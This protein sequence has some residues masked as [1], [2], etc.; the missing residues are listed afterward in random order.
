MK[1]IDFSNHQNRYVRIEDVTK[2]YIDYI[3]DTTSKDVYYPSYHI[4]PPHGLLNDPNGLC[5]IN[6]E[7]HIFYQWFPLGPV[8]GLKHWYHL[9]TTDFINYNDYGNAMKPEDEFDCRG[10]Y[11]GMTLPDENTTHIY[12]TGIR[13]ENNIPSVCYAELKENNIIKQG[14]ICDY[15]ERHTT[16]NFRD[17]YVFK[18]DNIYYMIVGGESLSNKGVLPI[19]SSND[20]INFQYKGELKLMDYPFGYMLECPNYFESDNKGVLFFSP[21]GIESPNKYDFRNVFSVV[22]AVGEELDTNELKFSHETFYEMDKGFDFYAPQSFLD[23]K[24]RR[25][26]YGWLGNSK[27]EY[28][29]DKNNWAH[30]LTIPREIFIE[31]DRLR[32]WPIKELNA[33]RKNMHTVHNNISI[34]ECSFEIIINAKENFSLKIKNENNEYISFSGGKKEYCLDRTHMTHLYNEKYGTERFAKR[35]IKEEHEIRIYV[36]HSSIEIFADNGFTIF[37]SRFYLDDVSEVQLEGT[38]G[39]FFTLNSI[40]KKQV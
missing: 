30:M 40:T 6:D 8:H 25:I 36:D 31:N 19:Y 5:Q 23:G 7:V 18:K 10:C 26:L 29:S 12:Y 22:Y 2:K 11:S 9:S 1:L 28:P 17:P 24:G 13:D 14:I 16:Y 20:P 34:D 33:L 4:A 3:K 27:C 35:L 39:T 38:I 37:T 32:Q 15:D 21:Q